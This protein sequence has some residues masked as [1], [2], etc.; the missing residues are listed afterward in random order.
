MDQ[1]DEKYLIALGDA[2]FTRRK[3]TGLT[4]EQFA[5]KIGLTK[6]HMS[7]IER[8]HVATSIIVL[9]KIAKELRVD[10]VEILKDLKP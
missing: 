3:I 8:G 4:Q 1:E 7:R 9:R 6:T 5:K 10:I 2:I